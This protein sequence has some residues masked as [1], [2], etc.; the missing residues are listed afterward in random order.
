MDCLKAIQENLSPK[1]KLRDQC[2]LAGWATPAR[3]DYRFAN[4]LPWKDRGGGTKGEQLN[5][6]AVH[7]AGW[8]T[9]AAGD[10]NGGKRPHP[11]TSMT[12]RHPSGRKVNMGL[13]SQAHIG[14]LNTAPARLT[15]AGEMLT[16]SSAGMDDGGQLN[17]A[18]SRWLMGLPPEWDDCAVTAMQSMPRKRKRS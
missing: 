16:G 13:A 12:G 17:P 4:A 14:F 15:A 1:I 5:N 2:L 6:Q 7:L 8:N 10:G 3:R 11:D 18:H 9:P